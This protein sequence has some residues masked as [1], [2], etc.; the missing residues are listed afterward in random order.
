MASKTADLRVNPSALAVLMTD[1]TDAAHGLGLA[2]T[3][4]ANVGS[5]RVRSIARDTI[6]RFI[7]REGYTAHAY[8]VAECR[9]IVDAASKSSRGSGTVNADALRAALGGPASKPASKRSKPASKPAK[10]AD[11]TDADVT[12]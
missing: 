11:V 9:Q 3:W 5:K 12:A 4:T 6:D 1:P 10:V 2:R 7:N 8:T